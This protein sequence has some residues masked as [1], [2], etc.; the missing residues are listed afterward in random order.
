MERGSLVERIPTTARTIEIY[1]FA[2]L[3]L[4]K[5]FLEHCLLPSWTDDWKTS[6]VAF[7]PS[8]K[9]HLGVGRSFLVLTSVL[10]VFGASTRTF[11]TSCASTPLDFFSYLFWGKE[12]KDA[13]YDARFFLSQTFS[14]AT[15][16]SYPIGRNSGEWKHSLEAGI[17]LVLYNF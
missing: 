13:F 3:W 15:G 1:I 9:R 7:S 10:H 14:S 12:I 4:P 8:T 5:G 2:M 17:P 11:T 6:S 16:F